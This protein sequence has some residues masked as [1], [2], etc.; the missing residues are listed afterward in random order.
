MPGISVGHAR[1]STHDQQAGLDTQLRDL[2]SA[3]CEEIFSEQIS[4]IAKRDR[5]PEA[6]RFVRRG[7]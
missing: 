5:L 4:A 7:D 6:P 1:V 2:A 3:G